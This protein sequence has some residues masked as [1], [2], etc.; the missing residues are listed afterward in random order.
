MF[1]YNRVTSICIDL[2]KKIFVFVFVFVSGGIHSCIYLKKTMYLSLSGH[3][4]GLV[5]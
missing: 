3:A 4:G 1:T 5:V 2:S